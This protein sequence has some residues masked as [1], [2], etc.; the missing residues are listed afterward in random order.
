MLDVLASV[1]WFGDPGVPP[2]KGKKRMPQLPPF[3]GPTVGRPTASVEDYLLN[4][5]ECV[6]LNERA[7]MDNDI[8]QP[9]FVRHLG[10]ELTGRAK[11]WYRRLLK[12]E[13]KTGV[14]NPALATVEGWLRA[15]RGKY[16]DPHLELVIRQRFSSLVMGRHQG[17]LLDYH[18]AFN[19]CLMLLDR[20][21]S[22]DEEANKYDYMQ[23]LPSSLRVSLAALPQLRDMTLTQVQQYLERI[24]M[25]RYDSG[26]Y[27]PAAQTYA[28][29]CKGHVMHLIDPIRRCL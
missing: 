6:S 16:A 13:H 10:M 17:A 29:G 21:G 7:I 19:E 24:E 23:G 8:T 22:K 27:L 1:R 12:E 5:V 28:A 2:G 3:D 9:E 25:A 15:V 11:E 4:V 14:R 20:L 18:S 26:F